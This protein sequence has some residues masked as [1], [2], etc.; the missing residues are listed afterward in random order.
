[1]AVFSTTLARFSIAKYVLKHFMCLILKQTAFLIKFSQSRREKT[2]RRFVR[3]LVPKITVTHASYDTE[4][5]RKIVL[6]CHGCSRLP[7]TTTQSHGL[8][9]KPGRCVQGEIS[10]SPPT[11]PP[12]T[13][14]ASFE[15]SAILCEAFEKWGPLAENF[16]EDGS[17][18][19]RPLNK[20][21]CFSVT[22]NENKT[23]SRH[24][25]K[26]R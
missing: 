12:T 11:L 6:P 16:R 17:G 15:K 7:L 5:T 24:T 20:C 14:L 9:T 21:S 1:M 10:K 19:R 4:Q 13:T 8:C 22:I 3:R 26:T 23:V 25:Q 18:G 2:P